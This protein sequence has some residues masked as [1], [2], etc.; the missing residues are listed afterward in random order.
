MD[1][2]EIWHNFPIAN[3]ILV[4]SSLLSEWIWRQS[5]V[6]YL[7]RDSLAV[8]PVV[9]TNPIDRS[10]IPLVVIR[11]LIFSTLRRLA[12][13]YHTQLPVKTKNRKLLNKWPI[14]S[15]LQPMSSFVFGGNKSYRPTGTIIG[16]SIVTWPR[17]HFGEFRSTFDFS[18]N[19]TN[20]AT[21]NVIRMAC[22][23]F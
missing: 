3:K 21:P 10:I 6:L 8:S 11:R 5:R 4:F 2:P 18:T 16:N 19:W 23:I 9:L 13:K 22:K 12:L 15:N 7:L 20:T 14:V 1:W 17:L